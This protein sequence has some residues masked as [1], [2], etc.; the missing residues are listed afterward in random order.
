[1]TSLVR[2]YPNQ[3]RQRNG[4]SAY[5]NGRNE[6]AI[7]NIDENQD[8]VWKAG[9]SKDLEAQITLLEDGFEGEVFSNYEPNFETGKVMYCASQC[10]PH[11]SNG[12]A[13]RTHEVVK[14]I[15]SKWKRCD[16]VRSPR[17]PIR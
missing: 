10:L 16:C 17:I 9:I 2:I 13:I 8:S 15:S 7:F 3:S 4:S 14:G 6:T 12:Y 5:E 11:T 1:M